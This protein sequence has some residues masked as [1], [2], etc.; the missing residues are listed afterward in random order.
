MKLKKFYQLLKY[1]T[2]LIALSLML[3]NS[4]SNAATDPTEDVKIL[5]TETHCLAQVIY[6]EARGEPIYGQIAVAQVTINRR[7]SDLFPNSI[8][9]VTR[10][11]SPVCQYSWYCDGKSDHL[12]DNTEARLAYALAKGLLT[13][14]V[15]DITKG[16]LFFHANYVNPGWHNLEKTIEIGAH[17][18]YRRN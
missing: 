17:V 6:F 12:P 11:T 7:D 4:P 1:N 9:K 16:A 18:F 3:S 8:C 10:E 5:E 15:V 13:T 14:E 2:A